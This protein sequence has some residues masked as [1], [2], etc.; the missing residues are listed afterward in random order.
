[1]SGRRAKVKRGRAQ[2]SGWRCVGAWLTAVART[3]RLVEL[4]RWRVVPVDFERQHLGA[5]HVGLSLDRSHQCAREAAPPKL[6]RDPNVANEHALR[7]RLR[8]GA[9][10]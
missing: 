9:A 10:A 1:M 4:Q 7:Q 8:K 2:T 3:Q 6:W 5:E